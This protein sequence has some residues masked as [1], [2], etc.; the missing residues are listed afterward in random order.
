MTNSPIRSVA[1]NCYECLMMDVWPRPAAIVDFGLD[2][3]AHYAA[4]QYAVRHGVTA[5]QLD[6]ALGSGKAITALC[7]AVDGQP[8]H[9][10]FETSYDKMGMGDDDDGDDFDEDGE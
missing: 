8:Y 7:D 10:D 6:A 9:L 5:E 4:L 3:P 2:S 1:A